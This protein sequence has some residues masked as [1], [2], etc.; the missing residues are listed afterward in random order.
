MVWHDHMFE[1][2]CTVA[3]QR[4]PF[5]SPMDQTPEIGFPDFKPTYINLDETCYA[6]FSCLSSEEFLQ[7]FKKLPF[8]SRD[9]D[10][11]FEMLYPNFNELPTVGL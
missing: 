10:Q 9:H 11:T 2:L 6:S 8:P 4:L 3:R 7:F 1:Y 5:P